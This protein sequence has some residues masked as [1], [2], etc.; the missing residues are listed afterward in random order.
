MIVQKQV[1]TTKLELELDQE[2]ADRI[3]E[4]QTSLGLDRGEALRLALIEP[5]ER[6]L[7]GREGKK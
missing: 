2:L 7:L 5:C 1:V 3:F 4:F 6:Y